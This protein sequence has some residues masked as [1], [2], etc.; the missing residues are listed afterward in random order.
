M[1]NKIFRE[2]KVS[3]ELEFVG[4]FEG[5]YSQESDPWHQSA[6]ESSDYQEY[7]EA[8]RSRLINLISKIEAPKILEIGCG[9]G[10]VLDAI[11]SKCRNVELS[12]MDISQ[13]AVG[14]AKE[15][16]PDFHFILSDIRSCD[17]K[18]KN[19]FDLIIVSQM[20]W[21]ILDDLE[22]VFNNV[23][24]YLNENGYV[25]VTQA[26]FKEKQRYGAD[27]INGYSGLVKYIEDNLCDVFEIIEN[28]LHTDPHLMHDDGLILMRKT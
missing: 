20:L 18:Y 24:Q 15:K 14:K 23:D 27:I 7:Y 6:S 17:K 21:Y 26:F 28:S 25:V 1:D 3:K 13:T 2:N 19:R 10:H 12:G 16:F 4:D 22:A 9:L 8:S 5:L 11:N